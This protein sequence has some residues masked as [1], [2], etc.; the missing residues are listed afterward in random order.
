MAE[1]I[2]GIKIE[3]GGKEQ[4]VS[5]MGELR[6]VLKDLKFEQLSLSEQFGATSEQAINAAKRIK[7]LED[8]VN[9]A[10]EATDQF[11]PGQRFQAFSTAAS[12]LAGAFGAV[13]HARAPGRLP[14]W[15][16]GGQ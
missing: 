4:V 14:L 8:R 2:V 9:Q 15:A 7:E 5:S 10:K 6:K 16:D 1:N 12:Q 13:Q 3:V 11:D